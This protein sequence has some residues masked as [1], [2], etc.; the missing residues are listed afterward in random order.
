MTKQTALSQRATFHRAISLL[1]TIITL[2]FASMAGAQVIKD[3]DV[4][5]IGGARVSEGA[6]LANM[7]TKVGDSLDTAVLDEDLK[8]LYESNLVENVNFLQEPYSGGMRLIVMIEARAKLREILFIGNSAISSK[9][10]R[11]K[12]ELMANELWDD[13]KLQQ[14]RE[15]ILK[16]YSKEG[17][18]TVDVSYRVDS[19]DDGYSRITFSI[20]EGQRTILDSI[21]FEGNSVFSTAE[22]TSKMKLKERKLLRLFG[23]SGKIDNQ[24][25]E[26]DV[27][28]IEDHYRNE[29][30]VNARVMD[31]DR[32]PTDKADHVDLIIIISEGAQHSVSS[33]SVSGTNAISQDSI[34]SRLQMQ[35]GM[36]YSAMAVREDIKFLRK[37][38][39]RKGYADLNVLPQLTSAG[40]NALNI[41]Y[42]IFE[43]TASTVGEINVIGNEKT[44]DRVIRRELAILPGE[45]FNTSLLE[46]SA[47]R[48]RQLPN[49]S[50]VEVS[51]TD[52]AENGFKDIRIS[53]V[54]KPTGTVNF[55]AGFSSIDSI[56][57]FVDIIQTNF[58]IKGWPKFTGAGQKFRMSLKYGTRRRDFSVDFTEPWL[59]DKKLALS[60]GVFYRDIFYNSDLY[61]ERHAG[62]EISLRKPLGEHSFGKLGYRLDFAK[63]H[64]IDSDASEA[65]QSEEGDFVDSQLFLEYTVDTRDS[66]TL[67][68]TGYKFTTGAEFGVGGDVQ[69]YAFEIGGA[70]YYTGPLDTIF[71]LEGIFRTIDG[72]DDIPIFKRE[73]L[74][75]A[76]NLR[77]YDYREAGSTKDEDGEPLGGQTSAYLAAEV[78]TPLPGNLGE[79]VRVAT[80]YDVGTV[81]ASAW[82]VDDVYSDVGIGVRLFILPGAP[83]RLDYGYPLKTD[84]FTGSGGKF[85]FQMGWNF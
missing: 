25:L 63:I 29:G 51:P 77:G 49:F 48:L 64:N 9:K 66:F 69:T 81:S 56:V 70:T 17:Y 75:G 16:M 32:R 40:T 42:S 24:T 10:L 45:P 72:S 44:Q 12:I 67:P 39:G 43:G 2:G 22:L 15:D 85:N 3:I 53:V 62:G 83:I 61:D 76:R 52:S 7:K 80:F 59:F 78:S 74:G 36:P 18:S 73:F 82:D 20:D 34:V 50:R 71:S 21:A 47:A 31:M 58:D 35:A 8:R 33:V 46:A 68:R 30:Y 65:I 37:Y 4:Q 41:E 27:L 11:N 57:G 54:E 5:Y 60:T 28:A 1:A 13:L 19:G 23:K 79:K 38:Y 14:A 26:D 55:G 6:V 84:E